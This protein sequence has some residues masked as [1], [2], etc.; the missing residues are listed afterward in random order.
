MSWAVVLAI[1]GSV[2][3]RQ[4]MEADGAQTGSCELGLSNMMEEWEE[5]R[6]SASSKEVSQR[7]SGDCGFR[8]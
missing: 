5:R 7:R 6:L 1:V 3:L 8:H 4:W 2:G